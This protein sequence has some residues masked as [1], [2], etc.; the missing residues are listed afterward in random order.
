MSEVN[1]TPESI[2]DGIPEVSFTLEV[3]ETVQAP[4]DDTLSISGMAAD[5]K[6]VGDALAAQKTELEEEIEDI[7]VNVSGV[8]NA[9]FPVGCVYISTSSTA[10][11]FGGTDWRWQEIKIP[12]THGD[13]MDGFRS[14][15]GLESGDTP[16]TLH[17]WKRIAN[18][19]VTT[20]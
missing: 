4:I 1:T 6:A 2:D 9:L 15:A 20:A 3:S 14:Y 11:A 10:P 17:F 19:E 13:L 12:V 7:A 16:G 8:A 18:A 5:A